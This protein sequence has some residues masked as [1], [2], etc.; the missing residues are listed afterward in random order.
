MRSLEAYEAIGQRS[1]RQRD[2][3]TEIIC[4]IGPKSWDPEVLA[5]LIDA[6]MNTVRCNMS[7]GDH[8]EQAM[9]LRNLAKAYD[10]R[11]EADPKA[12]GA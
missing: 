5:G 7:H 3:K 11:P 9:K 8:D 2:R 1:V 12:P 10:L 6:G 4:T